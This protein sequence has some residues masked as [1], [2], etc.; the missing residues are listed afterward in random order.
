MLGFFYWNP[1]LKLSAQS[2][3]QRETCTPK[4]HHKKEK[5]VNFQEDVDLKHFLL[6]PKW[7]DS[8]GN[9]TN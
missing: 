6:V 4:E 8:L 2:S 9:L 3:R 1:P 5:T 7:I